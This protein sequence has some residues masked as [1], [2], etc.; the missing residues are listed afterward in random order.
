M[1]HVTKDLTP[2]LAG[3]P[4]VGDA[5]G[6]HLLDLVGSW[7]VV[8]RCLLTLFALFLIVNLS[9]VIELIDAVLNFGGW[10]DFG[11][12]DGSLELLLDVWKL[13]DQVGGSVGHE[14][15]DESVI[16]GEQVGQVDKLSVSTAVL[17]SNG[18]ITQ[19]VDWVVSDGVEPSELAWLN[20]VLEVVDEQVSSVNETVDSVEALRLGQVLNGLLS[21][22][23]QTLILETV[24]DTVEPGSDT[25]SV[26]S[27]DTLDGLADKDLLGFL[28]L[29]CDFLF[30][31]LITV[32]ITVFVTVFVTVAVVVVLWLVLWW[33][34]VVLVFLLLLSD[35]LGSQVTV[36]SS[37]THILVGKSSLLVEHTFKVSTED[38][39]QA[40]LGGRETLG[41]EG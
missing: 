24:S 33:F 38:L 39:L 4:K 5:S 19:K 21:T 32:L 1:E 16:K 14:L 3:V 34:L 35:S 7:A 22:L 9:V 20:D 6:E 12:K 36:S 23:D 17:I 28:L 25:L 30:G 41:G 15:G 11:V 27:T 8:F 31:F 10:H 40:V 37:L 2:N 18:E 26:E 29:L 13:S